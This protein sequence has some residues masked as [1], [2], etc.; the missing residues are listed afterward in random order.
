MKS[1]KNIKNEYRNFYRDKIIESYAELRTIKE[2]DSYRNASPDTQKEVINESSRF[3]WFGNIKQ[4]LGE[5]FNKFESSNNSKKIK[6]EL[7]L[8]SMDEVSESSLQEIERNER[9]NQAYFYELDPLKEIVT[10]D[11]LKYPFQKTLHEIKSSVESIKKSELRAEKAKTADFASVLKEAR[12]LVERLTKY[13]AYSVKCGEVLSVHELLFKHSADQEEKEHHVKEILKLK[14]Q[15]LEHQLIVNFDT[16]YKSFTS[17]FSDSDYSLTQEEAKWWMNDRASN[18]EKQKTYES[19]GVSNYWGFEAWQS[20]AKNKSLYKTKSN[21]IYKEIDN[22]VLQEAREKQLP[23]TPINF[24]NLKKEVEKRVDLAAKKYEVE[25]YQKYILEREEKQANNLKEIKESV[26]AL[27]DT[28]EAEEFLNWKYFKSNLS[29]R[30]ITGETRVDKDVERFKTQKFIDSLADLEEFTLWARSNDYYL[31]EGYY[32]Q[33]TLYVLN[34]FQREKIINSTLNEILGN[35]F[36]QVNIVE[37]E[38]NFD[39][40]A[41]DLMGNVDLESFD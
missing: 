30:I 41:L 39:K 16:E 12:D 37:S 28:E 29:T 3:S 26:A 11:I 13:T 5:A 4:K 20:W 19:F 27:L 31:M 35:V 38:H 34:T 14:D 21:E 23:N 24:E 22:I 32:N 17:A 15:L 40:I 9:V 36:D 18:F 2:K 10:K 8:L 6:K 25:Q 7:D 1:I 33:H